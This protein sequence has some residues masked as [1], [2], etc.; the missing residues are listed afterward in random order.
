M[1]GAIV[2]AHHRHLLP[3]W[4]SQRAPTVPTGAGRRPKTRLGNRAR[5]V[6]PRDGCGLGTG[7]TGPCGEDVGRAER[8]GV[9]PSISPASIVGRLRPGT[10]SSST[11]GDRSARTACCVVGTCPRAGWVNWFPPTIVGRRFLPPRVLPAMEPMTLPWARSQ[12]L[13]GSHGRWFHV[14]P[15]HRRPPRVLASE[16]P[17]LDLLGRS[18]WNG[19]WA[20]RSMVAASSHDGRRSTWNTAGRCH[21]D[22]R[23]RTVQKRLETFVVQPVVVSPSQEA[24]GPRIRSTWNRTGPRRHA[25]RRSVGGAFARERGAV[26]VILWSVASRGSYLPVAEQRSTGCTCTASHAGD[27]DASQ[28]TCGRLVLR[29][30]ARGGGRRAALLPALGFRPLGGDRGDAG[31]ARGVR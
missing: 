15:R 3:S 11:Q 17:R 31:E 24:W 12:V 6:Q 18:T 20:P 10:S 4:A 7:A 19:R 13:R 25:W 28:A 2:F 29:A 1:H 8:R 21:T 22:I 16:P 5:R 27:L 26:R 9:A 23:T 14:E 30:G